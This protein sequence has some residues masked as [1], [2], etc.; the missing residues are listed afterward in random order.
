ML[1]LRS[2][3]MKK[4]NKL[5]PG[6]GGKNTLECMVGKPYIPGLFATIHL[7]KVKVSEVSVAQGRLG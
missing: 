4:K 3:T 5:V 6:V 1:L 7:Q 2:I